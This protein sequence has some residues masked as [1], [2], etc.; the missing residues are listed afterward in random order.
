[1]HAR[2]WKITLILDGALNRLQPHYN[3]LIQCNCCMPYPAPTITTTT[4]SNPKCIYATLFS[5]SFF[6]LIFHVHWKT[7]SGRVPVPDSSPRLWEN[8]RATNKQTKQHNNNKKMRITYSGNDLWR[9]TWNK[10]HIQMPFYLMHTRA[11][12]KYFDALEDVCSYKTNC[13][14]KS[15]EEILET[16]RERKKRQKIETI[17]NSKWRW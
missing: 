11:Q 13:K 15:T 6:D 10:T 14:W 12:H 17:S 1:M 8:A 7:L 4:K 5:F 9:F 3:V 2:T 16:R